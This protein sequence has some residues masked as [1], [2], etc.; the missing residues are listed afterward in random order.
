MRIDYKLIRGKIQTKSYYLILTSLSFIIS[1]LWI[2]LQTVYE[3]QFVF[4]QLQRWAKIV[5]FYAAD[6][7]NTDLIKSTVTTDRS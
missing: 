3:I 7:L 4:Q 1:I 5:S 6:E 2:Y